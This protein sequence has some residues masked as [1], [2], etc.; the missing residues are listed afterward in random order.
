M[1]G[2]LSLFIVNRPLEREENFKKFMEKLGARSAGL[3]DA[4]LKREINE[5][6]YENDNSF[7]LYVVADGMGGHLAGDVAS[8]FAVNIIQNIL[9]SLKQ[10]IPLLMSFLGYRKV[11]LACGVTMYLPV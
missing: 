9:G 10:K 7:G 6:Y 5:D 3:S 1:R 11:H 2:I 8:K 4:G